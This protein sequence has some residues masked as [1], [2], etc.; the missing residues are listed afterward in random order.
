[1][2]PLGRAVRGVGD[3]VPSNTYVFTAAIFVANGVNLFNIVYGGDGR[4]VRTS[5]I[6]LACVAS[7]LASIAWTVLAAKVDLIEKTVLSA[8]PDA[9]RQKVVRN[10]LWQDVW[11][12]VGM[13]LL[14]AFGLSI[15][16]LVVLVVGS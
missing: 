2:N 14:I 16:A 7:V 4:P 8:S 3:R 12:R 15:F 1:M 6:L 10:E 11:L 13:Y 5:V 9:G